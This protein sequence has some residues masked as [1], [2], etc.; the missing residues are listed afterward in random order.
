M[1][2]FAASGAVLHSFQ[3]NVAPG[4]VGA[5]AAV[6]VPI[7]VPGAAIGDVAVF[8]PRQANATGI[9][10][11][12]SRVSAADT[13]QLRFVNPTAAGITPPAT[14]DYDVYIIQGRGA[15]DT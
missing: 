4:L 7:T 5:A 6:E 2:Q 1:Y 10:F 8:A 13:V 11:G 14:D 9:V 12:T 3:S 15:V